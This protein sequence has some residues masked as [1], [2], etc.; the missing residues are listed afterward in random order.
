LPQVYPLLLLS[1]W[2]A[3]YY[4]RRILLVVLDSRAYRK[5]SHLLIQ[6]IILQSP[7]ALVVAE[8]SPS[9]NC[10]RC[11]PSIE[12]AVL[13]LL[14]AAATL[15]LLDHRTNRLARLGR[16][17]TTPSKSHVAYRTAFCSGSCVCQSYSRYSKRI[18][19]YWDSDLELE[20]ACSLSRARL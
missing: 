14:A 20:L 15:P 5:R 12:T 3:I 6:V 19:I 17:V 13:P 9:S 10:H 16:L 11:H 1:L 8:Y 2:T 18:F 7:V 4:I